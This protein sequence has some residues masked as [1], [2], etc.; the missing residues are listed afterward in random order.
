MVKITIPPLTEQEKKERWFKMSMTLEPREFDCIDCNAHVYTWADD[1]AV[2]CL[3][4]TWIHSMP[5]ITPE[6][7]AEIR[8]MTATPILQKYRDDSYPERNC[9]YCGN[10]YKGPAVYCSHECAIKDA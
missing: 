6:E 8:V 4:C 9:D 10:L 3:V 7:E 2:R 1:N 5:N